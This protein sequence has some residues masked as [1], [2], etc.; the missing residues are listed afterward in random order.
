VKRELAQ[1][2]AGKPVEEAGAPF[3]EGAIGMGVVPHAVLDQRASARFVVLTHPAC[4]HGSKNS[5]EV[6]HIYG[7]TR[8]VRKITELVVRVLSDVIY[9]LHRNTQYSTTFL[10]HYSDNGCN[11]NNNEN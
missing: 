1:L 9:I 4:T 11:Q 10:H 7:I 6:V 8:R 5:D 2:E 3:G